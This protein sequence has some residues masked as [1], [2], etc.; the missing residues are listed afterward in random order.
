[1]K[2]TKS[3][4][5]S[6]AKANNIPTLLVLSVVYINYAGLRHN[7]VQR[8]LNCLF[9]LQGISLTYY[10]DGMMRIRQ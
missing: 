2:I 3:S 10:I 7:L 1:M 5:L 9:L 8:S 6:A 4:F